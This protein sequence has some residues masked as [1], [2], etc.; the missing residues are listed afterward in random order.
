VLVPNVLEK[1]GI[2]TDS[3]SNIGG[4]SGGSSSFLK[5]N[6]LAAAVAYGK[7][8]N[9]A[10]AKVAGTGSVKSRGVVS[11]NAAIT[12]K[13]QNSAIS[14]VA[15]G[16]DSGSGRFG[17]WWRRGWRGRAAGGASG[18]SSEGKKNAAAAAVLIAN[19]TNTSSATIE[20][21]AVVDGSG[22]VEVKSETHIPY[23]QDWLVWKGFTLDEIE[24]LQSKLGSDLGIKDGFFTSWAQASAQGSYVGLAASVNVFNL[25]SETRAKIAAG[26]L[27]NQDLNYRS[28]GTQDVKVEAVN[29]VQTVNLSGVMGNLLDDG[30][31]GA[32]QGKFS[33]SLATGGSGG[34]KAGIGGTY[35]GLTYVNTTEALIDSGAQVYAS[36]L[37]V[38]AETSTNNVSVGA[39]GGQADKF[40]ING[41]FSMANIEDRTTA[42]IDD[43][44]AVNATGTISVKAK[45]DAFSANAAGGIAKGANVGAG[46]SI[47]LSDFDRRTQAIIGNDTYESGQ[48]VGTGTVTSGGAMLLD[49][50]SDGTIVSVALAAAIKS[51]DPDQAKAGNKK[52]ASNGKG[53]YGLQISGDVSLNDIMD[54]TRAYIGGGATVT[55]GTPGS[56]SGNPNL[57]L[58]IFALNDSD[59]I[60]IAGAVSAEPRRRRK[61]AGPR[62][63]LYARTR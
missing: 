13:I 15:G 6:G 28:V 20:S 17:R 37:A 3:D 62:R 61:V 51:K 40:A 27:V 18:G 22:G 8:S 56:L 43:G 16:E 39:S 24:N 12:D 44:A 5:D 9:E 55:S 42:R 58:G 11:V 48:A 4:D 21:G 10:T 29:D 57:S 36:A 53:D 7:H 45:D 26:A 1:L 2:L 32:L 50:Q 63:V 52:Q 14:E 46:V 38:N 47:A 30:L 41:T 33:S 34:G 23:Q 54:V 35:L 31:L 25:T 49:A 60:A 59:I 19:H